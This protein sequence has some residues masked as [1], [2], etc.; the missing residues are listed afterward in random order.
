M[1]LVPSVL[2]PSM[3]WPLALRSHQGKLLDSLPLGLSSLFPPNDLVPGCSRFLL[4]VV[5]TAPGPT[6]AASAAGCP[7]PGLSAVSGTSSSWDAPRLE[8]TLAPFPFLSPSWSTGSCPWRSG[9]RVWP[10]WPGTETAPCPVQRLPS[11]CEAGPPSPQHQPAPSE[12]G[13]HSAP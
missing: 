10:S 6:P 3:E 13:T 4:G 9:L 7:H 11:S 8:G 12:G 1:S 2:F 5:G